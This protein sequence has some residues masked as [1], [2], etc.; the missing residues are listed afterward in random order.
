MAKKKN[1]FP[2][3]RDAAA[4]NRKTFPGGGNT[5]LNLS[6]GPGA[7]AENAHKKVGKPGLKP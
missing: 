6:A 3:P 2:T 5:R 4:R 1:H 7:H